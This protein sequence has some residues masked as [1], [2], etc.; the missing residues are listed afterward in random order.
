[1]NTVKLD[2]KNWAITARTLAKSFAEHAAG[3]D[4]KGEF[5]HEN[6]N[7]LKADE[8][9]SLLVPKE[10]GGAGLP[11]SEVCEIIR[12]FGN[13][14][15]STAL[16]FSMHQHLVAAT[17]W[18]YKHKGEGKP[19]LTNVADNQ[20]VLVSTGARDWLAS[21]GEMTKVEGGYLVN[22]KKAFASQ[23]ATGDIL[24]TSAPYLNEKGERKVL[25]FGVPFKTE[26]LSLLDDWNVMGMR[27]TGSQ[28][29]VLKDVF[30]SDST[31]GLERPQDE[32]HNVWNIVITVAMPLI[33][34]AYVGIAERA[35]EIVIDIA[36]N[37]TSNQG[38]IPYLLGKVDNEFLSAKVQWK[39]MYERTNEFNFSPSKELSSEIL[40]LKTNV[41]EACINTIKYAI[42]LA[43]GRSYYSKNELERLFR[44][45]QAS[46]FHPLPKWNQYKFNSELLMAK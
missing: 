30:V 42:E 2:K 16:A 11:Y 22:A 43:G 6:Y 15:G 13:H 19:L 23:S 27:G 44:D 46:Q 28:T 21:N 26:G 1:M 5:V 41:S 37:D 24:V 32:F 36:K 29:V 33:M 25:H 40:S 31:I 38:H 20:L 12:I 10:L 3:K 14:C 9:F 8:F 34:S 45:V 4:A 18:K 39:A 17:A 35:R 7:Q